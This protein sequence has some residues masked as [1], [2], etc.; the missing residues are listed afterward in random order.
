MA[1]QAV[2]SGKCVLCTQLL[3][4]R[5]TPLTKCWYSL[6]CWHFAALEEVFGEYVLNFSRENLRI[7]ALRGKIRLENVQLDG[8]VLGSMIL[9]TVGLAGFGILSCSAESVKISVPWGTSKKNQQNSRSGA[10]TWS[11]CP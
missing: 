3:G 7:A 4:P 1:K 8:E 5:S 11:V 2:I 10:S 6:I 9:G